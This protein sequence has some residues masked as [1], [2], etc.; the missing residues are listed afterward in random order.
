M[1]GTG[2]GSKVQGEGESVITLEGLRVGERPL[3]KEQ[4]VYDRRI[5]I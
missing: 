3:A 2:A 1:R 5:E 4:L